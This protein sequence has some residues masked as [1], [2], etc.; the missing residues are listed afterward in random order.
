MQ[1]YGIY[2][3]LHAN[4]RINIPRFTGEWKY[5]SMRK[6]PYQCKFKLSVTSCIFEV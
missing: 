2:I 4:I 3:S 5:N 6:K 1:I